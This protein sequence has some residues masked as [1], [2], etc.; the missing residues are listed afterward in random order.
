[1]HPPSRSIIVVD[2]SALTEADAAV[3]ETLVRMQLHAQ[4]C[5]ASIRLC[6]APRELVDLLALLGL[7][8]IVPADAGSGV[9]VD[10]QIEER[11]QT[12]V[13]EEVERGDPPL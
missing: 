1:M 9:E 11:E 4:R 6:N 8:E 13:D 10:R 12:C 7:S 5:G 2:A 3:V